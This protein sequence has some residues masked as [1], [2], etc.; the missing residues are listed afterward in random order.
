MTYVKV[1]GQITS[2][3]KSA[4]N[5]ST[6][7]MASMPGTRFVGTLANVFQDLS[8]GPESRSS[9][10]AFISAFE[11]GMS[12]AYSFPLAS[13]L[14]SRASLSAQVR[15]SKVVTRLP[16][17]ALWTLVVANVGFA[18]LG[19]GLAIW[20]MRLAS[21]A[22]HQTQMRLGVAGLAAALFDRETFEQSARG[23]N[24]LFSEKSERGAV[25]AKRIGF[26]QTETGGSTFAVYDANFKLAE[27]KEMR[28]RYFSS[29]VG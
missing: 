23:D 1:R 28:K 22:V 7:G 29:I 14:S 21:P 15:S 27:A 16:V 24:G 2:L 20:A 17:A 10:S 6:A 25:D 5:G 4:S 9:P 13:Q 11:I 3:T 18:I 26:K 8:T 12:K 19:V